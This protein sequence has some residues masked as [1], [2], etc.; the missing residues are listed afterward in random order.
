MF[1]VK[2]LR[3][4]IKESDTV[5]VK[6]NV[7]ILSNSN[8]NQNI[9]NEGILIITDSLKSSVDS[10]FLTSSVPGKDNDS[11]RIEGGG[12]LG[13]VVFQDDTINSIYGNPSIYLNDLT[14]KNGLLTLDTNIIVF[15]DVELTQGNLNL[16][17]YHIHLYDLDPT[18]NQDFGRIKQGTETNSYKIYDDSSGYIR[19]AKLYNGKS[20]PA[21]LGFK[22]SPSSNMGNFF[23]TRFHNSD[24]TVTDGGIKKLFLI[25]DND[26]TFGDDKN[27]QLNYFTGDLYGD[28]VGNDSSLRIFHKDINGDRYKYLKGDV[29]IYDDSINVYASF[30]PGYYT[31]ADSI[32]D[33]PP[34]VNLGPD[35]VICEGNAIKLLADTVYLEEDRPY[36]T[37]AWNSPDLNLIDEQEAILNIPDDTINNYLNNTLTIHLIVEDAKGCINYDTIRFF[38]FPNPHLNIIINKPSPNICMGDTVIF[39]DTRNNFGDY[40]WNFRPENTQDLIDNPFYVFNYRSGYNY[41]NIIYT[42][43]NACKI[44]TTFSVTVHA[45]PEPDFIVKAESCLGQELF[46]DN[47]SYINDGSITKY[48]WNMG[49]GN[50]IEVTQNHV[51]SDSSLQF[52]TDTITINNTSPDLVYNYNKTGINDINLITT[53]NSGC[54]NDTTL[55]TQVYDSVFVAFEANLF[56][57]VCFGLESRFFPSVGTSDTNLVAEYQWYFS[58][59]VIIAYNLDDTI[60]YTFETAGIQN[61]T[62]TAVSKHGC[63][64]S[65]TKTVSIYSSPLATFTVNPECLNN[66]SLFNSTG[67]DTTS[68]NYT[69]YFEDTTIYKPAGTAL[70]YT[71]N[72]AG[73]H[74]VELEVSFVNGCI[75][76]F[77]DSAI[78]V[79]N[80]DANFAVHGA[81]INN[82]VDTIILNTSNNIIETTYNWDFGDGSTSPNIEQPLKVYKDAGN[83]KVRLEA[84]TNYTVNSSNFSC[85]S[86][87]T[88][89]IEIF[90][91]V[92]ADFKVGDNTNVC[93]GNTSIFLLE[94][95]SIDLTNIDYYEWQ[96]ETDTQTISNPVNYNFSSDGIYNVT[97]KT[98]TKNGCTDSTIKTVTIYD[99]PVASI[100]SDSVCFGEELVFS[101]PVSVRDVNNIYNWYLGVDH[102]GTGWDVSVNNLAVGNY[103]LILKAESQNGCANEDTS[104]AVVSSLPSDLFQPEIDVCSDTFQLVGTNP[105]YDYLWNSTLLS[106]AYVVRNDEICIVEKTNKITGCQST[107]SIQVSLNKPLNVDLGN[108]TSACGSIQL[109]AGYFGLSATYKWSN[110]E[111]DR[112]LDVISTGE[113]KV[114]VNQGG[115]SVS[116]SVQIIVN[117]IPILDLGTDIEACAFETVN[118]NA[119]IAGGDTYIWSNSSSLSSINITSGVATSRTYRVTVTDNN[120]CVVT[121]KVKVT[122]NPVPQVDLGTD[123]ETCQ[124]IDL[125]LNAT[126][127]NGANYLWSNGETD[128]IIFVSEYSEN[129]ITKSYSVNVENLYGCT[130]TDTIIVQFNPVLE[131]VL[132]DQVAC[133]NEVII[134]DAYVQGA[135]SYNW[136][137][138]SIDS[139]LTIDPQIDGEGVYYVNVEN[140]YNCIS[141]SNQSNVT[142]RAAPTPVLPDEITGCNEVSI[143]AGNFGAEFLW[144]DNI[145]TQTRS[146][147]QSGLY[148]V[149][150][151]NGNNCTIVDSIEVTVNYI[152]KPYLGPNLS[153]CTNNQVILRTGLHD[154]EYS[155]E[156]N[157][158]SRGDTMLVGNS[159]TYIVRAMHSNGC[160]DSDTIE[161]IGRSLPNVDLGP[162]M[163]KCTDDNFILDAGTDGYAYN[164]GNTEALEAYH[165]LLEVSDTGKYWV[166]VTNDYGCIASDTIEIKPTSLSIDPLFVTNSKLIAGDSVLFVDMSYPEPLNWLW[167][168]G[169]LQQ[170]ILQNPVHVY[171]GGGSY[172]VIMHVSNSVCNASIIK[173]IE[174]EHRNKSGNEDEDGGTDLFGDDFIE[175]QNVKIYPNPNNGNFTLEAELSTR[176]NANVYIF[177]L[178]GRLISIRK[179]SDV[180]IVSQDVDIQSKSS[181]IY[182]I[183]IIAGTDHK[184]YKIIKQ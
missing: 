57:N 118:L 132:Q 131:V 45:L 56:T 66:A 96:F 80:P 169:D 146:V 58:D 112:Y 102:I 117:S 115:C 90:N 70:Y 142:F 61:V 92:P 174:V 35:R 9:H 149:E 19:A 62:L 8:Q 171:Y 32:C 150:I 134:L 156:W 145:S 25:E 11:A 178:M 30:H 130:N 162:D 108:D 41:I 91:V 168:F 140:Q 34:R 65:V 167:E 22:I 68:L 111:T 15:G 183:K 163:Y 166:Q 4:T 101:I 48:V 165:R 172:Q 84:N 143:D 144:N 182:I 106:N 13:K 73:K 138:G 100:I 6:G 109:D 52:I 175:I 83:Y 148:T 147:Y 136:N 54:I 26:G 180:E 151:T 75:T 119:E 1:S 139:V 40:I 114:T 133:G 72:N 177:D 164:W 53:S 39:T 85:N 87:Y 120:S 3:I 50:E 55:T 27:I 21:N 135:I 43:T 33:N 86:L 154:P 116:D 2:N 184:T 124:N 37:Y 155:F 152:T 170:S 121:D 173:I 113:Y 89:S 47:K 97:L 181:G 103:E 77:I 51:I 38:T 104:S 44:D 122:Y 157:G 14:V 5:V 79:E 12:P 153:L 7:E 159:G 76:N 23:L 31:I 64:N 129:V 93:E 60:N 160:E 95:I 18:I 36:M 88:D 82:Q 63:S 71:F 179:Y 46:L 69:W 42:D 98:V 24:T 137:N 94:N 105:D 10:L 161:I 126:V 123:I 110:G 49:N 107:E 78:I 59:T 29:T 128:P 74:Q 81:C 176:S 28:L 141:T 16:N 125:A 67:S 20:D 17:R 127:V 158:Y 99:T